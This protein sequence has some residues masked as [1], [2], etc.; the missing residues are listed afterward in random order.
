M[1]ASYRDLVAEQT[2]D[3]VTGY[4]GSAG[5]PRAERVKLLKLAWDIVGSEFA[6]RHYQHEMFQGG[7]PFVARRD[8]H[9]H[10]GV[11]EPTAMVEKFL[12]GYA[13]PGAS[14]PAAPAPHREGA[15]T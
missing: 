10:Y 12:A 5:D 7:A 13:L 3:L 8:S 14:P 4:V 1:P 2:R 9:R 11:G 6:G 15:G